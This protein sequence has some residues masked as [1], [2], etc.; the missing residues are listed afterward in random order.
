MQTPSF[1]AATTTR[2]ITGGHL[3]QTNI[4]LET[5]TARTFIFKILIR[6]DVSEMCRRTAKQTTRR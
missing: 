4:T 2:D 3:F 5:R 1:H 6:T